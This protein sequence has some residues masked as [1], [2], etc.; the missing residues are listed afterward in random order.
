MHNWL[1]DRLVALSRRHAASR[2]ARLPPALQA[3]IIPPAM[4]GSVGDA[5]MVSAT[6]QQLRRQGFTRVDVFHGSPWPLDAAIDRRLAAE[7]YFYGDSQLHYARLLRALAGYSHVFFLGADVIDGA[8]NP[9]SV[10]RRLQILRDAAELGSQCTVLGSSYNNA[11]EESTRQA[12]RALPASV[13]IC[14]R[15]PLSHE[16]F[17]RQLERPIRQTA[18]VALLLEPAPQHPDTVAAVEW[19]DAQR[20]AGLQVLA[21]NA[22]YLH[23]MRTP[24]LREA[25]PVFLGALLEQDLAIVLLSHDSRT[26]EP[27]E[28]VLAEAVALLPAAERIRTRMFASAS[29]G[30]VKSML[31]HVDLLVT[32]RMHAM[33]LALGS[34]TPAFCFA[35]QDKF[36]GLM[37]SLDLDGRALLSSP[38]ELAEDPLRVAQQVLRA[39]ALVPEMRSAI[40][41]ALPALEA[42]SRANFIA[43]PAPPQPG[44][45]ALGPLATT[46]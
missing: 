42:L 29:P 35:Y 28:K 15:D 4:P 20:S 7:R 22:N 21:V 43:P 25:L 34:H 6:A 9:G 46:P 32:G 12:L 19:I 44:H 3:A 36:E 27:D 13:A 17:S 40:A 41:T 18:D 1:T 31:G 38:G 11:P 23:A 26:R 37:A 2:R 30:A 16:R 10:R 24:G 33:I 8:Y 14:G 39:L 5:A 45:A